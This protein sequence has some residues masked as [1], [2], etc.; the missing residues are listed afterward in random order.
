[1]AD[2]K[3]TK[4]TKEVKGV[5]VTVKKNKKF[6]GIGAGGVQFS[7]GTATVTNPVMIDWFKNHPD[8]YE[9]K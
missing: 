3:E 6:C 7:N 5:T 2:T 8:N 9:V 1:M 4:E